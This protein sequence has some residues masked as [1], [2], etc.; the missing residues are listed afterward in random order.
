MRDQ[1]LFRAN[2][3][4]IFSEYPLEEEELSGHEEL[5]GFHICRR[6]HAALLACSLEP[7]NTRPMSLLATIEIPYETEGI[8]AMFSE[9]GASIKLAKSD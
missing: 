7:K 9:L 4:K 1:T 6:V 3:V 2:L 8:M 5:V